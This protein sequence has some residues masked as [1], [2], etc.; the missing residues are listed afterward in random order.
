[1]SSVLIKRCFI[2]QP[3]N[4][5]E[6]TVLQ[7]LSTPKGNKIVMGLVASSTPLAETLGRSCAVPCTS[8][9]R[10][11]DCCS[12]WKGHIQGM[13]LCGADAGG[14][15]P[16]HAVWPSAGRLFQLFRRLLQQVW[17][18]AIFPLMETEIEMEIIFLQ[19][20]KVRMECNLKWN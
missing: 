20:W 6:S 16:L 5:R 3:Y 9:C 14:R 12:W 11:T 4:N 1:M 13:T 8:P 17:K 15:S 19:K 2:F 10:W 18:A 7:Y